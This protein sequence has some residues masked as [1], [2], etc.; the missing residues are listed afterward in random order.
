MEEQRTDRR[1]VGSFCADATGGFHSRD[2]VPCD[3]ERLQA[4]GERQ[5]PSALHP[6]ISAL[7]ARGSWSL[8]LEVVARSCCDSLRGKQDV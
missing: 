6:V 3:A 5:T 4:G 1:T 7:Q 8:L 2:T